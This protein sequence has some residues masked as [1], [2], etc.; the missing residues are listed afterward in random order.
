[1]HGYFELKHYD[2][3]GDLIW[4]DEGPNSLADQGEESLLDVF[5]RNQNAPSGFEL[6]LY[7]DTPIDTDKLSDL[8]GEPST[9]GYARQSLTRDTT[10]FPTLALDAGDFM[11]TSATKTFSASGGSWGPVTHCCLQTVGIGTPT[12]LTVTPVGTTGTTTWGYRVTA[13]NNN[14]EKLLI[15]SAL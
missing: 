2:K 13:V 7:N 4:Q 8:V 12:G 3:D 10:G 11:L 9:N 15:R 14:G 1:M 6:A 5:F